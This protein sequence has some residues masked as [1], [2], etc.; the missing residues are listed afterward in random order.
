MK[1]NSSVVESTQTYASDFTRTDVCEKCKE[2]IF[3]F[4]RK[5]D[6]YSLGLVFWSILKAGLYKRLLQYS[7]RKW[8]SRTKVGR[9]TEQL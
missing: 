4:Y 9:E 6:I 5:T 8:T 2:Q 7:V 1:N 3:E